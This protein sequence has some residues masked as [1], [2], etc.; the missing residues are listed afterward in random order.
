MFKLLFG[1]FVGAVAM[2][3]LDPNRGTERRQML[4]ERLHHE[5]RDDVLNNSYEQGRATVDEARTRAQ[6]TV[7]H[8]R[9]RFGETVDEA[10]GQASEFAQSTQERVRSTTADNQQGSDHSPSNA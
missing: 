6:S 2:Y 8:A 1:V 10:R 4:S 7:S 9:E 3:L 5:G